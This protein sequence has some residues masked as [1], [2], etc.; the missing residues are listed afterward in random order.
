MASWLG[1]TTWGALPRIARLRDG[2]GAGRV[3]H[4]EWAA[5]LSRF[6]DDAG[7]VDYRT[8]VRVQRL[9]ETYLERLA[10]T[11]P[12]AFADTD[13]QLAFYLNAYNA[14]AMYQVVQHYPVL[15]LRA[16]PG[17]WVRPFPV[18][19]RNVSLVQLHG[20]L[21]RAFGDPRVHAALCPATW[22][23]PILFN[24]P[25][26]GTRLQAQLADA[27]RRLLADGERGA[28]YDAA[29]NTLYLA[30]PLV[31]WAGDWVYPQRMP[32]AWGLIA[33]R[34]QPQRFLQAIAPYMPPA[35]AAVVPAQQLTVRA[36]PYD[37]TLN[38]QPA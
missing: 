29:T 31:R 28:R 35:L 22:G 9:M 10:D 21:V 32:R 3:L 17:A 13:D 8:L 26:V 30:A 38:E 6:V 23:G 15:S 33:G 7:L 12:D 34:A 11:D 36:L 37:W 16:V 19:R 25:F 5:L 14:I 1:A 24:E 2:A 20:T 27:L 4:S 18:G